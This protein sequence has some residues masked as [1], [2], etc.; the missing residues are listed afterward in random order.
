VSVYVCILK[1]EPSALVHGKTNVEVTKHILKE[2]YFSGKLE[3]KLQYDL[4]CRE[5]NP[6]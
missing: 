1:C 6:H 2:L 5:N 3:T 4:F